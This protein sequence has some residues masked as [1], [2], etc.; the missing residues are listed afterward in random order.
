MSDKCQW[1]NSHLEEYFSET[2]SEK[3]SET[4]SE[5]PSE[6][7]SQRA[8]VNA[9][10]AECETCQSEVDGY[11]AVDKLV[12]AHFSRQV[13]R[14]ES[15]VRRTIQPLRLAGATATL[16]FTVV[17]VWIG[18]QAVGLW[19]G[20]ATESDIQVVA[21]TAGTVD[22]EKAEDAPV[23]ERAKPEPQPEVVPTLPL[24]RAPTMATPRNPESS[25]YV[26]DAAGYFHTLE[27]FA[28][29]VLV[30]GVI[31]QD[32]ERTQAFS[33]IYESY[34]SE[35]ELRFL[36][37]A[38]DGAAPNGVGFPTM[39]NRNSALLE[40]RAG[41]FAIIDSEGTLIARG[42]LEREALGDAVRTSL[43]RLQTD[44]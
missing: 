5:T 16:A 2:L 7:M 1:V 3:P 30:L 8:G 41:E 36:G 19:P 29:S 42:A 23:A 35:P 38:P 28:G 33:E 10:L 43:D 9:H 27:D 14:A 4:L 11:L 17:A 39:A 32:P 6:T 31:D 12:A 40:T 20:T 34:R 24:D 15:P 22:V 18:V 25:F 21:D 37:V 13:A 44:E 26:Q